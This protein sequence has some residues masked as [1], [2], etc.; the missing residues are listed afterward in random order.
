MTARLFGSDSY[1]RLKGAYRRVLKNAG[2]ELGAAEITRGDHSVLGRYGRPQER[3]F[4]PIDVVADLEKD[5]GDVSVTRELADLQ[6]Y[7]LVPK[8]PV[9]GNPKWIGHLAALS[10]EAGEAIATVGAAL[11]DDGD[12]SAKEIKKMKLREEL[13]EA[14]EAIAELDTALAAKL[15]DGD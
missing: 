10:K 7:V 6:D 12:I 4:P 13:R 15:E 3:M 11:A 14:M 9:S 8:P 2:G 1:N 5:T